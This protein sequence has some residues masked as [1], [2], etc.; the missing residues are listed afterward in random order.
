MQIRKL[1]EK[2]E[3]P[4]KYK[5]LRLAILER[6]ETLKE[7][8]IDMGDIIKD[9]MLSEDIKDDE[10]AILNERVKE[11]EQQIVKIIEG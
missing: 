10:L 7:E 5:Y 9:S 11:L 6:V 1:V 3:V 8:V 2:M 4:D